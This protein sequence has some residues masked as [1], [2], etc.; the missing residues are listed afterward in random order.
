M[1]QPTAKEKQKRIMSNLQ[2]TIRI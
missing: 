2:V 1:S